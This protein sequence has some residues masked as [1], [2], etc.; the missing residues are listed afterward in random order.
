[1]RSLERLRRALEPLAR[2]ARR[3][4]PVHRRPADLEA[5]R[6]GAVDEEL[7]AARGLRKRDPERGFD[8]LRRQTEC[9][10]RRCRRA[11]GAAGGARV[12][13]A[14]VVLAG[15][16]REGEPAGDLVP[17]DDARQHVRARRPIH[18]ARRHRRRDR[19][20]PRMEA[21]RGVRVVEI[22]RMAERAVEECRAGGRIA[23]RIAEHAGIARTQAERAHAGEQRRRAL[24]LGPRAD[25][26]ADQVEHQEPRPLGHFRRQPPQ[27]QPGR[28]LRKLAGDSSFP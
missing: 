21:A 15:R 27:C 6:P 12:K 14:R 16:Q 2:E 20:H 18:L 4:E 17:R 23:R 26:I 10:R 5:L 8:R 1:M 9:P 19:R 3:R 7:E 13:A 11:E 28:E 22:E 24:G 25:D